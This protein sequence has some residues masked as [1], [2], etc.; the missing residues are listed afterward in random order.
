MSARAVA[1]AAVATAALLATPLA[2]AEFRVTAEA[3]TVLY[4]A[5]SAKARP[6][7]V[8]G[9]DVPVE[10]LVDVDGWTKVRDL[11]GT[12]GWIATRALGERRVLQVR[13][14][15]ADIRATAD[16]TSPLVFR[17]EQNVLLELAEPAEIDAHHPAHLDE[18]D[19][20]VVADAA[21]NDDARSAEIDLALGQWAERPAMGAL[22]LRRRHLG[23]QY[24]ILVPC[25]VRWRSRSS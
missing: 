17:A 18:H 2:A 8:F 24:A 7:F 13:V 23:V 1:L 9:R 11:G 12:I 19:H 20:D 5:P 3:P 6:Q 14:P 21:A 22:P 25:G 10:V 15:S 16:D 4:D